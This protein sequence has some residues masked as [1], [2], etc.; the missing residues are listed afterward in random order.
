VFRVVYKWSLS[1][2]PDGGTSRVVCELLKA[3]ADPNAFCKDSSA[4]LQWMR[5]RRYGKVFKE[6]V[7]LMLRSK[8]DVSPR[9]SDYNAL[10]IFLEE[11]DYSKL[12]DVAFVRAFITPVVALLVRHGCVP[13]IFEFDRLLEAG[14]L[15]GPTCTEVVA[16]FVERDREELCWMGAEKTNFPDVMEAILRGF[17]L[18]TLDPNG[19]TLFAVALDNGNFALLEL[20]FCADCFSEEAVS[21]IAALFRLCD[22][23]EEGVRKING[24]VKFLLSKMP[25]LSPDYV[26]RIFR[27]EDYGG[28]PTWK[29][30]LENETHD[31]DI[32]RRICALLLRASRDLKIS[33]LF[34]AVKICCPDYALQLLTPEDVGVEHEGETLYT[35][36]AAKGDVSFMERLQEFGV[37]VRGRNREGRTA[38]FLAGKAGHREVLMKLIEWDSVDCTEEEIAEHFSEEVKALALGAVRNQQRKRRR[39][40]TAAK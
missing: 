26:E 29:H 16:K 30:V 25:F 4:F 32:V 28:I 35:L 33:C 2:R 11:L 6:G 23:E 19:L 31:P 13:T 7:E 21:I 37:D 40:E 34:A 24:A 8:A 14:L 20:L 36:A 5:S 9:W 38:A 12:G 10:S 15:D 22:S 18:R 27:T 17:D 1:L 39:L 3:G